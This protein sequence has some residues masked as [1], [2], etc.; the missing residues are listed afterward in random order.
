MDSVKKKRRVKRKR[1]AEPEVKPIVKK[2]RKTEPETPEAPE[3]K[4]KRKR[5]PAQTV[6][7]VGEFDVE[8]QGRTKIREE[9]LT[10][11]YR[12]ENWAVFGETQGTF[13]WRVSKL[14]GFTGPTLGHALYECKR[15]I[16]TLIE[17]RE[18][19]GDVSKTIIDALQ[20]LRRWERDVMFNRVVITGPYKGANE[21]HRVE[22]V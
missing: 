21:F 13:Q 17:L 15:A 2:K 19:H 18:L 14:M 6:V 5:R 10:G 20:K 22:R 7:E 1:K 9:C 11:Q 3:V 8:D 12:E 4:K 16:D